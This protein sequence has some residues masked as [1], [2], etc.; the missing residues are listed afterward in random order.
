MPLLFWRRKRRRRKRTIKQSIIWFGRWRCLLQ[1]FFKHMDFMMPIALKKIKHFISCKIMFLYS[2]GRLARQN[3]IFIKILPN[4]NVFA[5]YYCSPWIHSY[6]F[7]K[8]KRIVINHRAIEYVHRWFN[9]CFYYNEIKIKRSHITVIHI[10]FVLF[11]QCMP[12]SKYENCFF[13]F[14]HKKII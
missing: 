5:F 2:M 11:L 3:M 12:D 4:F 13:L 7:L 14:I 1:F 8:K 10:F 6:V 9:S